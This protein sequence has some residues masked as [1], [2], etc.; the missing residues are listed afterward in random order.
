MWMNGLSVEL[1]STGLFLALWSLDPPLLVASQC[2][3]LTERKLL[4][5]FTK[6][7]FKKMAVWKYCRL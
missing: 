6:R 2:G 1:S 4:N 5:P 3:Q 7:V